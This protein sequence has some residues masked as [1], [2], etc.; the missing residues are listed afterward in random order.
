MA[1]AAGAAEGAQGRGIGG[2]VAGFGGGDGLGSGGLAG[3]DD[4]GDVG[5]AVFVQAGGV[6]ASCATVA[7]APSARRPAMAMA[8]MVLID[9]SAP[10]LKLTD[11]DPRPWRQGGMAV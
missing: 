3:F 10:S 8:E 7:T 5:L 6:K 1:L 4:V 9:M 11:I 2:G